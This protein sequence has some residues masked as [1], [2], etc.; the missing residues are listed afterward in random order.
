MIKKESTIDQGTAA[1]AA[2]RRFATHTHSAKKTAAYDAA[3]AS[4]AITLAA[5]KD[6]EAFDSLLET[7]GIVPDEGF[8]HDYKS[9]DFIRRATPQES[10]DSIEAAKSDKGA[11]VI[12]VNGRS[13]YVSR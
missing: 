1:L 9:G 11:G 6:H 13:C 12:T 7:Y 4:V 10:A 5:L 2:Y 3:V 8:L